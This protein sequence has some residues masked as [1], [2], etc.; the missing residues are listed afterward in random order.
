MSGKF[1]GKLNASTF[2]A[3][4]KSSIYLKKSVQSY[5]VEQ[6]QRVLNQVIKNGI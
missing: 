3:K 6:M 1:T 2:R 4:D 5:P